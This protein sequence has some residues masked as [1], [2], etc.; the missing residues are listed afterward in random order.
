MDR[1]L[2]GAPTAF[3]DHLRLPHEILLQVVEQLYHEDLEN[4]CLSSKAVF[5]L[6]K[7]QLERHLKTRR[8]YRT[9][10]VGDTRFASYHEIG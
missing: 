2:D 9:V 5:N 3:F 7:Q 6:G 1:N 10:V 8:R 4:I